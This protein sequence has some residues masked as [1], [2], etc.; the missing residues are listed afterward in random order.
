LVTRSSAA[1]MLL[2]PG[3]DVAASFKASAGHVIMH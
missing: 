3:R 2:R 1:E